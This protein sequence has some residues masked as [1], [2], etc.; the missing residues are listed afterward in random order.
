MKQFIR[1]P[2]FV[3]S[4]GILL[5]SCNLLPSS[6]SIKDT[7]QSSPNEGASSSISSASS[8]FAEDSPSKDITMTSLDSSEESIFSATSST[9]VSIVSDEI[10]V[11]ETSSFFDPVN[12]VSMRLIMSDEVMEFV[13]YYQSERGKYADAYL[14]ANLVIDVNGHTSTLYEVGVRQKGNMSRSEFYDGTSITN[15]VHFKISLKATFD[16]ELYNDPLL[17]PFKKT[18]PSDATRKTRKKRTF[19]GYDK[20]DLKYLPRNGYG[21]LGREIYAYDTFNEAGIYAPKTRTCSF[22]F[23]N[24]GKHYQSVYQVIETIDKQFLLRRFSKDEAQGDLYKCVYNAMGK[25]DFSRNDAVT[26]EESDGYNVGKRIQRGKIGVEDAYNGYFPCYQLKTNDDLGEDSSFVHM[27]G[28]INNLWSCVYGSG[29]KELL[30]STIDIDQFLKFSAVSYLLGNFD[31]QRYNN[32]NFYLYFL[33]STSKPIFIPYDWDWCLGLGNQHLYQSLPLDRYTLDWS[34][35]NN[36]FQ[37][38]FLPNDNSKYDHQDYI[39]TYLGYVDQYKDKVLSSTLFDATLEQY[40]LP[41][42][43]CDQV[44]EYMMYKKF[45]LDE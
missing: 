21:C 40:R 4:V 15:P 27:E 20:F 33:P 10:D 5:S 37:A 11:D 42:D 36:L 26:K 19:L 44:H 9:S 7:N 28:F 41:N 1:F 31:D 38:T 45:A 2:L 14:P 25:A 13:S 24:E 6:S 23:G 16:G 34:D 30:E 8:S 3:S 35:P 22:Y 17:S 43:E 12:E 32:N 39:D 29:D 18:W